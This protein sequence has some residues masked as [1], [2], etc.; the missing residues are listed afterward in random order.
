MRNVRT[1]GRLDH[2]SLDETLTRGLETPRRDTNNP[3]QPS[4]T[5]PAYGIPH[6]VSDP[7]HQGGYQSGY[8]SSHLP[9]P[10]PPQEHSQAQYSSD[11]YFQSYGTL[12][13]TGAYPDQSGTLSSSYG[14]NQGHYGPNVP[15]QTSH[16]DAYRSNLAYQGYPLHHSQS[17]AQHPQVNHGSQYYTNN[18]SSYHQQASLV[19]QG[20]DWFTQDPYAQHQNQSSPPRRPPGSSGSPDQ[21]YPGRYPIAMTT[22]PSG[23]VCGRRH[24]EREL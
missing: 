6:A 1:A 15:N 14:N 7:G 4:P 23:P 13:P 3:R 20:Q 22:T 11:P 19:S 17:S 16:N 18:Q 21:S 10:P 24:P 9:P 2:D 8:F 12:H 5:R